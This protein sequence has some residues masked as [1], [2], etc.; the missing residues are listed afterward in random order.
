MVYSLGPNEKD[1]G[2]RTYKDA[3]KQGKN[4]QAQ[5]QYDVTFK[6]LKTQ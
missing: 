2:G 3:L 6:V 4:K 1:D 5:E